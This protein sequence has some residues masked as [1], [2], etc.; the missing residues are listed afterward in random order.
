MLGFEIVEKLSRRPDLSFFR[1]RQPLTDAFLHIG[2]G[3]NIEQALVGFGILHDSRC[4]SLHRKHH[5][6][7]CFLSCFKS[8]DRRRKVVSDWMSFVM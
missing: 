3:G 1:V 4:L 6:A 8:P 5:G 7:L 2:M